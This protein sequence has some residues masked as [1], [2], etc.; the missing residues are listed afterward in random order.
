MANAVTV[1]PSELQEQV[2]KILSSHTFGSSDTVRNLLRYLARQSSEH[3]PKEHEIATQLLGRHADF[4]PKID[5]VIRVQTS[6]LRSKLAEYYVSEG[7]GDRIYVEVPKGSYCL[8]ATVRHGH[9]PPELPAILIEQV[10]PPVEQR[11]RFPK[12]LVLGLAAVLLLPTGLWIR[13]TWFSPAATL[14]RFWRPF[15]ETGNSP[16]V[17]FSNPRFV[18]SS[19]SSMRLFDP[20]RDANTLINPSYTGVGEVMSVYELT[21]L[22]GTFDRTIRPKRSQLFTW[23]DARAYNLIFLG[24]PPHNVPLS[25]LPLAR[26]LQFKTHEQEP[27]KGQGCVRNLQ[28]RPG[29]QEYYCSSAQG[30]NQTEYA[31]VTLAPSADRVHHVL[32][33]AGTSTLGTQAAVEF[34]CDPG[35]LVDLDGMLGI[36]NSGP[37]PFEAILRCKLRGGA[38][39]SADLVLAKK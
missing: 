4:D 14:A 29:E 15:L 25:Q 9:P 5:P 26:H 1:S 31:I 7:S 22:F 18:G 19:T 36:G 33:F 24:A 20:E 10:P 34:F 23:D 38:A 39:V 21:R 35:R 11:R 6:R 8:V 13:Q 3:P 16:L 30:S 37:Q 27:L 32:M 17:I 2:E 12:A 28:P